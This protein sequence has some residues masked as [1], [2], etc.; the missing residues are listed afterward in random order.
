MSA[1]VQRL[2][3]RPTG[4]PYLHAMVHEAA[5]EIERQQVEVQTERNRLLWLRTHCTAIGMTRKSDTGLT[6]HDI[7]LFTTDLQAE[8]QALKADALMQ[9]LR[10]AHWLPAPLKTEWGCGML[11]ADIA[12]SKDETLTL[13]AS[14]TAIDAAMADPLAAKETR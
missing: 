2:R 12:L 13:Y 9:H 6:E 1:L 8:V 7:A 14:V 4:D 10:M 3:T 5:D 11:V